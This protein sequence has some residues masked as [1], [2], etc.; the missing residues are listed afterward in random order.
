MLTLTELQRLVH[1]IRAIH[2]YVTPMMKRKYCKCL[3][4]ICAIVLVTGNVVVLLPDNWTFLQFCPVAVSA[5]NLIACQSVGEAT[6]VVIEVPKDELVVD[7]PILSVDLPIPLIDLARKRRQIDW[8]MRNAQVAVEVSDG[9]HP[10]TTRVFDST[11]GW[12]TQQ[13][14]TT[15]SSKIINVREIWKPD[16]SNLLRFMVDGCL[17]LTPGRY[18]VRARLFVPAAWNPDGPWTSRQY[19]QLQAPCW[20]GT[21][22]FREA[23]SDQIIVA[24]PKEE[25]SNAK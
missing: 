23:V 21:V 25:P 16:G 18:Q 19:K 14:S 8:L 2:D 3:N 4:I 22:L 11:S 7:T 20:P 17:D 15:S 6:A 5:K 10:L 13:L 12:W 1:A 9:M 24:I